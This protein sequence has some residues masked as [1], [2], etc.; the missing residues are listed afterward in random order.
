MRGMPGGRSSEQGTRKG[1]Q[2]RDSG[3]T[4][5]EVG[6]HGCQAQQ[7]TLGCLAITCSRPQGSSLERSWGEVEGTDS[8]SR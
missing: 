2:H 5:T 6:E 3:A 4:L 7:G 1:S 8:T